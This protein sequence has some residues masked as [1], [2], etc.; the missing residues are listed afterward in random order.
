MQVME[1]KIDIME[2]K[3]KRWKN[4]CI[5][6]TKDL[7][8]SQVAKEFLEKV[9]IY[10]KVSHILSIIQNNN[11][12]KVDY[13]KELLKGALNLGNIDFNDNSFLLEK[14]M[15]ISGIFDNLST[16]DEINRRA[17]EEERIKILYK[18]NLDKFTSHHIP[19]KLKVDEKG[20][21]K[22]IIQFEDFDNEQEFIESLLSVLNKEMLNPYVAVKQIELNKLI[23]NIYKYQLFLEIFLDYQIYIL[24]PH[25]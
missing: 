24:I 9:I 13:L 3:I 23:T 25:T 4:L 5:V 12:Q 1:I 17:N 2:E 20:I 6:S 21:S 15:N 14:I 8:N 10:E 11:I 7:D 16:L 22:Y 18:V 19:F